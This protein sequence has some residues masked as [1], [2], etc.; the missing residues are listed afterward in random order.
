M[1]QIAVTFY[2][3]E[4]EDTTEG[5]VNGF[6]R[7]HRNKCSKSMKME[8]GENMSREFGQVHAEGDV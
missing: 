7:K 1:L 2:L 3:G 5:G 8:G 4:G 6:W